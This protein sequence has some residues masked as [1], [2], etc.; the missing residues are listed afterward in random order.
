MSPGD[1]DGGGGVEGAA[2]EGG[3]AEGAADEGGGVE[4]GGVEGGGDSLGADEAG[5]AS[6]LTIASWRRGRSSRMRSSVR[7]GCTR[8]V[9]RMA[10]RARG[11][12]IQI[13]QPVNPRWPTPERG[14]RSP[15]CER[16]SPGDGPSH[17]RRQVEPGTPHG[18]QTSRTR[19]GGKPPRGREPCHDSTSAAASRDRSRAV[20]NRPA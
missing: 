15:A 14:Q 19:S 16:P 2:D 10:Q 1:S 5:G 9:R 17:P 11:G 8:L 3:G 6:A 18:D 4:G 20:E 7:D 12:S 13:E